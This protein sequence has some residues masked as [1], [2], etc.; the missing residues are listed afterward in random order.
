VGSLV[1]G[2][3]CILLNRSLEKLKETWITF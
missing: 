1:V 3:W 2:G